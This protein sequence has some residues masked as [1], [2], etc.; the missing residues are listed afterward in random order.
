[1]TKTDYQ[2]V[3]LDSDNMENTLLKI[4]GQIRLQCFTKDGKSKWDTGFIKNIAT[5]AGKAAV[6]GLVGN[7]GGLTAFTY[8]AVGTSNT[9]V[10]ATDTALGAEVSTS[11][12]ARASA[13]V[14]RIT[15]TVTND[16]LQLTYTWTASGSVTVQEVGAFNAASIG[17]ML[18][19]ALTG[20]KSVASGDILVGTY[21]FKFS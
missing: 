19:H 5:N 20:A 14:S 15:T 11:G 7:T 21:T 3:Q 8:L 13:T 9:A 16:T 12:L 10:N 17:T 1:M 6:A 18:G 2:P 4:T